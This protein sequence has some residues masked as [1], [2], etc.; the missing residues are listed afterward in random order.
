[1][2][3]GHEIEGD[4]A[5]LRA[6]TRPAWKR[7]LYHALGVLTLGALYLVAFWSNR[8]RLALTYSDCGLAHADAV[9]VQLKDK[10]AAICQV[11]RLPCAGGA[12]AS[13]EPQQPQQQQRYF[14]FHKVRFLWRDD[15][16]HAAPDA[17]PALPRL[18]LECAAA[19]TAAAEANAP[20]AP[21]PACPPEDV[22]TRHAAEYGD[23]VLSVGW[24]LHGS[25]VVA[26][27]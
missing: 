8:V 23:N 1:M 11:K 10:R 6:F 12:P 22:R 3:G 21:G 7:V 24:W 18:A 19:A 20:P 14:E 4:I 16:F 5:R 2:E 27:W 17:P 26:E 13:G 25:C 15:A 9:Y